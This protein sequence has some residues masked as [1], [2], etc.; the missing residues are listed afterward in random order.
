MGIVH[1]AST[2]R[3]LE[4]DKAVDLLRWLDPVYFCENLCLYPFVLLSFI[5]SD[6]DL[7]S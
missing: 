3:V 1:C 7:S 4:L 6:D 2:W 5:W